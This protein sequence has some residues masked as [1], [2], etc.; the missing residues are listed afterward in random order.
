MKA[1]N[2]FWR[3]IVRRIH[4]FLKEVL[5]AFVEVKGFITKDFVTI[6]VK[7]FVRGFAIIVKGFVVRIKGFVIITKVGIKAFVI[8]IEGVAIIIM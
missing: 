4:F 1:V 6:I 2:F 8:S 5:L 7:G 3:C